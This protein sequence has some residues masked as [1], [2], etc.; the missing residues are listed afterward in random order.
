MREIWENRFYIFSIFKESLRFRNSKLNMSR[1]KKNAMRHSKDIKPSNFLIAYH[2]LVTAP[3]RYE[4]R[5]KTIFQRLIS[6]SNIT[7]SSLCRPTSCLALT[8]LM[9]HSILTKTLAIKL[10]LDLR[11]YFKFGSN[12]FTGLTHLVTQCMENENFQYVPILL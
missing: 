8:W 7:S 5:A 11:I 9:T 10:R 6:N 3:V 2:F 1:E 4:T 12:Q